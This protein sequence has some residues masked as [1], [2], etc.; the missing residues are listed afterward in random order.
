MTGLDHQG[1]GPAAPAPL[2][3]ATRRALQTIE[4]ARP[5]G[6]ARIT[7]GFRGIAGQISAA[8][9]LA[10]AAK[11]LARIDYSGRHPRLKITRAGRSQL[12]KGAR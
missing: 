9:G 12:G 3:P 11:G 6:L 10:L 4:A 7:G 1:S 8:D 5:L 2:D